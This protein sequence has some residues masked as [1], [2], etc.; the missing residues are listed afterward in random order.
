MGGLIGHCV[1]PQPWR[2]I[3]A[4]EDKIQVTLVICTIVLLRADISVCLQSVNQS[5]NRK[6]LFFSK[7]FPP[8]YSP[9]RQRLTVKHTRPNSLTNA[10]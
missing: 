9:E 1:S 4:H 8:I 10:Q 5:I 7:S 2:E 6:H 3:D